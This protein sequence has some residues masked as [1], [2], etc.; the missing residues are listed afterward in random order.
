MSELS[1]ALEGVTDPSVLETTSRSR[2]QT[3]IVCPGDASSSDSCYLYRQD[4]QPWEVA[5]DTC[6]EL[7]GYLVAIETPTYQ[8]RRLLRG[9]GGYKSS[10]TYSWKNTFVILHEEESES[11]FGHINSLDTHISFTQETCKDGHLAFLDVEVHVDS[12]GTLSTSVYRKPTHTDQYLNFQSHHP[13]VHKLAVIRTLFH[14]ADTIVHSPPEVEKEKTNIKNALAGCGYPDWAFSKADTPKQPNKNTRRTHGVQGRKVT[15][16][17]PYVYDLSDKIKRLFQRQGI[18]TAFKP[19]NTLRQR[20]VH[21]KDRV[22]KE[23]QR[24]VVYGIRCSQEDCHDFYIGETQQSLKA[25]MNQ[26]RRPSNSDSIPDSAVYTHINASQHSFNTN[27]V[28]ILDRESR[29]FERRVK[30]AIWERVERPTLNKRGGL[31]FNL[32]HAWDRAVRKIPSRLSRA[33]QGPV[34]SAQSRTI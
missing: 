1:C 15:I 5:R 12:D 24:N 10:P 29:W 30:E 18:T 21:V 7:G 4:Q 16:T 2:G 9:N 11:F 14:R 17:I 19:H 23:K 34:R 8:L 13:L 20:L 33:G 22:A 31:R 27:E 3:D 26:H 6:D 25:R 28:I 32:S